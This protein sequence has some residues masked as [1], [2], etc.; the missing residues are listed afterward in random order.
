MKQLLDKTENFIGRLRW[1]TDVYL[2]PEKYARQ[3]ETYGFRTTKTA[4]SSPLL[5]SFEDEVYELLAN[6]EFHERKPNDVFQTKMAE[7]VKKIQETDKIF[8]FADKT[9]NIYQVSAE[10]YNK[11]LTENVTKDYKLV[12]NK[13]I[14]NDNAEAKTICFY[15]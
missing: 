11:M 6:L 12:E 5:K 4:P 13:K 1:A 3:K 10:N 9:S 14:D 7:T 8:L 2:F 15:H